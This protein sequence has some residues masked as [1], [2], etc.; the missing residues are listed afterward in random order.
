MRDEHENSNSNFPGK[1][2][3][4]IYYYD[5]V[6]KMPITLKDRYHYIVIKNVNKWYSPRYYISFS[7]YYN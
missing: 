5:L 6:I 3:F 4:S 7:V 2:F 1:T